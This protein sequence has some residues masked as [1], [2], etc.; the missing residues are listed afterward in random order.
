MNRIDIDELRRQVGTFEQA[1]DP[2][3]AHASTPASEQHDASQR[4]ILA[5]CHRVL[6]TKQVSEADLRAKLASR[7]HAE[8]EIDWVIE[9]CYAARLLDDRRFAEQWISSRVQRGHGARRIRQ[10]LARHGIDNHLVNEL[11][12]DERDAGSFD[13][14]ALQL[15]RRRFS[16]VDLADAKQHAKAMRHLLGR[17]FMAEQALAALRVLRDEQAH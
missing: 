9:R 2:S 17:G 6:S 15:A 7:N 1:P 12:A 8:A 10:D 13:D 3:Y 4:A 11:L 16:Q 5:D 14:A